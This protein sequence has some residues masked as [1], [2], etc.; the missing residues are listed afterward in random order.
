MQLSFPSLFT[1]IFIPPFSCSRICFCY[2]HTGIELG[3]HRYDA[4]LLTSTP[5]SHIL[6]TCVRGQSRGIKISGFTP[7]CEALGRLLKEE[8]EDDDENSDFAYER[9]IV[10]RDEGS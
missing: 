9:F 2:A 10:W 7:S 5:A 8:E 4:T 6:H 1:I 3:L